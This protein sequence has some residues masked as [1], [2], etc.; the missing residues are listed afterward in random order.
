MNIFEYL[1]NNSYPGRGIIAGCYNDAP[2]VAY[3]IMGRSENSRNRIFVKENDI[4]K[5]APYDISKVADPSLIIYN[6]IRKINGSLIVTNGNQT[7][8]ICDYLS[9]GKTFCE[10][11]Q[12]REYE[13]DGPNWTPRIS[14]I[15]TDD[16]YQIA[17]LRKSGDICQRDFWNYRYQNGV[18]HFIST[19]DH[20]GNPLPSFSSE[21]L[22]ISVDLPF[23]QFTEKLWDSLNHDN[24]ISLYVRFNTEEIIY[25][26]NEE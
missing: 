19:Y 17:I 2:V 18:A 16:G 6:A 22:R 7:D 23:A 21:P 24:R 20:D 4:L 8:T 25:N 11:L 14:A 12:T 3:F 10:A 9:E 26:R 13:P 1:T 15:L 5:T